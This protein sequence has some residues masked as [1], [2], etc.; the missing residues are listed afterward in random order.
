[1]SIP[2]AAGIYCVHVWLQSLTKSLL[3]S[4]EQGEDYYYA[5]EHEDE[6]A[7]HCERVSQLRETSLE[8]LRNHFY[9]PRFRDASDS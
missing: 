2:R 5:S 4:E 3:L 9:S 7:A 6:K 8:K 1:M